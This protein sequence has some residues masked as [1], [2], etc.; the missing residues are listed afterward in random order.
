MLRHKL[1]QWL[2]KI[3]PARFKVVVGGRCVGK[4]T[5]ALEW[6][7]R[8]GGGTIIAPD[9]IARF[10]KIHPLPP[11]VVVI[12]DGELFRKA[13]AWQWVRA[14]LHQFVVLEE[15]AYLSEKAYAIARRTELVGGK[16]LMVSTIRYGEQR[17]RD[18]YFRAKPWWYFSKVSARF[19]VSS[20]WGMSRKELRALYENLGEP[21]ASQE[22][23]AKWNDAKPNAANP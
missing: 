12:A 9:G 13:S 11:G 2:V 18:A 8:N 3:H 6:L 1:W 23:K 17:F 4:T 22:Y 7:R 21:L 14:W 20:W 5:A 10:L 16:I 19:R 15:A